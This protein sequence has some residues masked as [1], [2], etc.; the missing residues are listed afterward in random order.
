[1]RGEEGGGRRGQ[2][3]GGRR[4]EGGG[5]TIASVRCWF[6]AKSYSKEQADVGRDG[7]RGS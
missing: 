4:E 3:G 2:E 6:V 5:R 1:V 7:N